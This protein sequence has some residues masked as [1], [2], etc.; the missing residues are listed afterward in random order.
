[1]FERQPRVSKI[2]FPQLLKVNKKE[3]LFLCKCSGEQVAP[4]SKHFSPSSG[5]P[6]FTC[7]K[8]EMPCAL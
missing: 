2:N 3:D 4:I 1:M 6:E 7:R 8:N 5:N